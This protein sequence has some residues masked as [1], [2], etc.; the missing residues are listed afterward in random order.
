MYYATLV[1]KLMVR[2][3]EI[4]LCHIERNRLKFCMN[5]PEVEEDAAE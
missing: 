5:G 1:I 2:L 3:L 4:R